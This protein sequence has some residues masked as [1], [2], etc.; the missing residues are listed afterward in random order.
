MKIMSQC[1][2]NTGP[3]NRLNFLYAKHNI[4]FPSFER[5]MFHN[6]AFT[7]TQVSPALTMS[8]ILLVSDWSGAFGTVTGIGARARF[9]VPIDAV[10][11]PGAETQIT[12][13]AMNSPTRKHSS[14]S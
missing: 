5:D 13:H 10:F 3:K 14:F 11:P 2:K 12:A 1:K 6:E 7:K 9:S 4:L 8:S